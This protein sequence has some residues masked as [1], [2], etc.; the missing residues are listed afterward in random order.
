MVKNFFFERNKIFLFLIL[1]G[2]F[3]IFKNFNN[4]F[5]AD[6]WATFYF[7]DPS[8]L[9]LILEGDIN[10]GSS[11]FFYIILIYWNKL[12]GYHPESIRLF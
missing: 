8:K 9:N 5:W 7:S 1:F 12:F 6:E 2:S 10:D 11:K 4:G 3:L